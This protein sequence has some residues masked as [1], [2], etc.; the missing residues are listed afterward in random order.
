MPIRDEDGR[1]A[2]YRAESELRRTARRAHGRYG[3]N[4]HRLAGGGTRA[5][6]ELGAS[7]IDKDRI[8]L[9]APGA[10]A[11]DLET[12]PTT[13]AEQP[14]IGKSLGAVVDGAAGAAG[15]VQLATAAAATLSVPAVGP[16]IASGL[17]A[18]YW[19]WAAE[20][21]SAASS[22]RPRVRAPEGQGVHLR[23][24]PSAR[25]D[26]RGGARRE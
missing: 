20:S 14:G 12:V 21:R 18:L 23:E 8:S 1:R 15:G 7:R 24:C 25:P 6:P 16:V 11:S 10:A 22:S 4:L 19:G 13:E 26:S 5:V 2:R 3:R 17:I 9:L